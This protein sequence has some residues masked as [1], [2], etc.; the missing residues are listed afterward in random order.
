MAQKNLGI[1]KAYVEIQCNVVIVI[2]ENF[3][4]IQKLFGEEKIQNLWKIV[5]KISRSYPLRQKNCNINFYLYLV[6]TI[7]S[8]LDRTHF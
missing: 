4:Y 6:E 7:P 5:D 8:S 1:D 2:T 3:R